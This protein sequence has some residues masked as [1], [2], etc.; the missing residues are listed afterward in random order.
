MSLASLL[1][2]QVLIVRPGEVTN[3][4]GDVIPDWDDS[5]SVPA[6]VYVETVTGSENARQKESTESEFR[7]FLHAQTPI[8]PLDRIQWGTMTLEVTAP[9]MHRHRPQYGEHHLEVLANEWVG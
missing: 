6:N 5:T 3:A 8:R 1:T 4:A 9:A 2:M 7:V